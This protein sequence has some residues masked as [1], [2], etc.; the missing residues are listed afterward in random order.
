MYI[1]LKWLTQYEN[2]KIWLLWIL[3][4]I[5]NYFIMTN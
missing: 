5:Y 1:L 3:E 2:Y 4:Q